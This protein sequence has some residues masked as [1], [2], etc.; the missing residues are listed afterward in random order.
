MG[1][2][3]SHAN[4]ADG[5]QFC[6]TGFDLRR[7]PARASLF[8]L[9]NGDIGVR[10]G[11]DELAGDHAAI[12]P[13]AHIA[14]PIHYHESFTGFA[15]SSDMRF[16]AP[17][18]V[19]IVLAVDGQPFAPGAD[20]A[21]LAFE[22]RLDLASG[23]LHRRTSWQI[24]ADRVLHL[25]IERM[26]AQG[27]GA[28]CAS[29]IALRITGGAAE[30]ALAFPL[31]SPE[32]DPAEQDDPRF[33]RAAPLH[34]ISLGDDG[35]EACFSAGRGAG[36]VLLAMA[37]ALQGDA[38]VGSFVPRGGRATAR[39]SLADGE[40]AR[41]E[42]HVH[43]AIGPGCA[44]RACA[45]LQRN[46]AAGWDGLARSSCAQLERFW[47]GADVA[48]VGDAELDRALHLAL[49]HLYQS[50]SRDGNHSIA[51]KGLTGEGYEGHYFWD[52]EVFVLPVLALLQPELAAHILRYRIGT[53][54]QAR[55]NARQLG[56]ARGALYPWRTIGGG[57][58]SAHYPTGAA[59][60][61][62]NADIAYALGL[63]RDATGD[64]V[65]VREAAPMLFETAR[66]WMEIGHFNPRRGGA[67]TIH[68]VTG[69]DEYTALVD[70]DYYTNALAR[71]HLALAASLAEEMAHSDPAQFRA[72]VDEIALI[73]QE[74]EQWR[75][76]AAA[77]WLPLDEGLGVH[78]QDDTFLARPVFPFADLPRDRFP[79]LLHHH[80]L[81]LFRH[82]L[83]KQGDV[84]QALCLAGEEVP[85]ATKAR[86]LAYYAPLTTHDST[87]SATAFAILSAETGADAQALDYHRETALVDLEDR[88][89]NTHHGVHMAAMAGSWLV[90]AMGWAGLRIIGGRLHLRPRC[91]EGWQSYS[92]RLRW[93]GALL[94]ITVTPEGARYRLCEGTAQMVL[95]HGREVRP[96]AAGT[97][98]PL[99]AIDAVIFD[100]DGVLTDTARAHFEAWKR[101]CDEEGFP[102]DAA[103][104]ERL[105]GVDRPG[106]L[107][108]ILEAAG[109]EADE[110][111][112][113]E[114]MAR[115]NGYYREAIAHY[116][117]A[118]LFPGARECLTACIAAGL[119]IGLASASRNARDVVRALGI[120]Q[121]FDTITDAA[122]VERGKPDPE[123]FLATA[124]ALG[125][126]PS[127]CVGVEDAAAGIAAI[128]AAGM[129]AIGIGD[130]GALPGAE[131]HFRMIREIRIADLHQQAAI[132]TVPD[133]AIDFKEEIS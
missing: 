57:E 12:L 131:Q 34:R 41:I 113:A 70:N 130:P 101:M 64:E 115:K 10:G 50:A 53:L 30:V 67:F 46:L 29:R 111:T 43:Y 39:F 48:I 63:Y 109:V 92:F 78:P 107:A 100:L 59:Q 38:A 76:A 77:M 133:Q 129:R 51:A 122:T 60:Y 26:V 83:C 79:L 5:W 84:V 81:L 31:E 121:L 104:N 72:L 2:A 93:R 123:I 127:R 36:E 62:I 49:F 16:A 37:Q 20:E 125:C 35:L 99:P 61:H 32:V 88:H 11:L 85:L 120:E 110:H 82:Q 68:G 97:L 19:R 116:G 75:A 66:I 28:H 6:Q 24:D 3:R 14:H 73:P 98:V 52:T 87:L 27:A 9:A 119:R 80:P 17:S 23:I 47:A 22:R 69:P 112:R 4:G 58:C 44:E 74:V 118:D 54:E 114:L 56:H 124:R 103:F 94:E 25:E 45:M 95:D 55:R 21:P 128:R 7:E 132:T 18:P 40:T 106:S 102:F 65:L 105:K 8:A 89:G 91:P 90:L 96:D 13:D 33:N 108:L 42:R 86:D 1:E 117:P 15:D 71:R 126:D